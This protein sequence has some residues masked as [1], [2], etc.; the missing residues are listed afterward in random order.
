MSLVLDRPAET[1]SPIV[2]EARDVVLD[3]E[4][5]EFVNGEYVEKPMGTES[6]WIAMRLGILLGHFCLTRHLGY[7]F[8]ANTA[9]QCYADAFPLD[10]DKFRKPDLAFIARGR[11]PTLPKGYCKTVPDLAVEVISP[12]DEFAVIDIKIWEYQKIGVKLVW[13]IVPDTKTV[14]VHRING[15]TQTLRGEGE[16]SGEDVVPGFTC[17]LPEL[18]AFDEADEA[19]ST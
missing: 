16:L 19:A 4:G 17:R 1:A 15:T 9:F 11:L 3:R 7:L 13:V 12:G 2:G 14:H 5:Y 6:D 8:G 10:A 18:F